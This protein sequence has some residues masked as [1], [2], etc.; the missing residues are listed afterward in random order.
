M[1]ELKPIRME[2]AARYLGYGG[3]MPD[4]TILSLMR[5]CEKPLM[6]ACHPAYSVGIFDMECC[7]EAE[8]KL[9][10]CALALTGK[11]I[12]NHLVGCTKVALVAATLG[13]G[14]DTLLR[15]LQKT[16][17]A[18]ALLTD[19]MVD[20][21]KIG[22]GSSSRLKK[23]KIDVAGKTGTAHDNYDLWFAGFTKYYTAAIWSGFDEGF[24]QSNTMYYRYLW[25]NV[26]DDVHVLKQC[27]EGVKFDRPAGITSAKVCTKCGK[28]AVEG[29]CDQYEGDK[30]VRSEYFAAGTAPHETCTCHVKLAICGETGELATDGCTNIIVKVFLNKV[31]TKEAL[32]H[33]GTEDTKYIM[34]EDKNH[35]CSLHSGVP[36]DPEKPLPTKAP[37]P[38]PT[39]AG[40][41]TTP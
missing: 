3:Q 23:V 35:L 11:D 21:T 30:C 31:E 19:A 2:E 34:P 20:T 29:L 16:E 41:A 27:Q 26:M 38:T 28:L 22:T 13:S 36:I 40:G 33:G 8:V 10:E 7:G 6:E 15:R 37:T 9:A 25:R 1:V 39:P 4:E 24:E 18:K 5:E 17:M 14:V 12:V 32:E